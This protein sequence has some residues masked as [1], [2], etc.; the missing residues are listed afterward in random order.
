MKILI[1]I[2]CLGMVGCVEY[3][4]EMRKTWIRNCSIIFPIGYSS[5]HGKFESMEICQY[6][7]NILNADRLNEN[8]VNDWGQCAKDY[9]LT[10]FE[11]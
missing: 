8:S 7:V 6:Y 1:L 10:C 4:V 11:N 3:P 5:I 9:E 2:L